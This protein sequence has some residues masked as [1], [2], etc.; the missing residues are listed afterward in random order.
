MD[1]LPFSDWKQNF[2]NNIYMMMIC[3]SR[4]DESSAGPSCTNISFIAV[5]KN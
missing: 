4:F 2:S 1:G 5:S 3:V